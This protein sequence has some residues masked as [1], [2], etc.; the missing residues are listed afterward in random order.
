MDPADRERKNEAKASL[1]SPISTKFAKEKHDAAENTR[2]SLDSPNRLTEAD[3]EMDGSLLYLSVADAQRL[4]HEDEGNGAQG[5]AAKINAEH[6]SPGVGETSEDASSA[7]QQTAAFEH[8][9]KVY[10]GRLR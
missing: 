6:I 7:T 3:S 10:S 9:S 1:N 5:N 8:Q 2:E 4:E